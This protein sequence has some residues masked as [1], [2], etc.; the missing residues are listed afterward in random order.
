MVTADEQSVSDIQAAIEGFGEAYSTGDL[1]RFLDFC[2]DDIVAMPP[3]M[4]PI[5]GME[6]WKNLITGMFANSD[7]SDV[8]SITKDITVAGD[9]AIEWHN[10]ATTYTNKETGD[11]S[12]RYNKGMWIFRKDEGRWKIA[13]YCWNASPE[14]EPE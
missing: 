9:W 1:D 11:S 14:V 10:E 3:G 12:R 2:T 6:D 5:V 4:A 13:R 8:V 7:R